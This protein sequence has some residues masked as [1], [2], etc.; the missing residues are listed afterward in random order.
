M[1]AGQRS[2][3]RIDPSK[4]E[5]G[6]LPIACRSTDD[7]PLYLRLNLIDHQ[8]ERHD[9]HMFL[10]RGLSGD[11]MHEWFSWNDAIA[12]N[13]TAIGRFL[14]YNTVD[15]VFKLGVAF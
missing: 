8:T 15:L 12:Y 3:W 5:A 7:L 4:G 9:S 10:C 14:A 2:Y 1:Q 13:A 11:L 6:F